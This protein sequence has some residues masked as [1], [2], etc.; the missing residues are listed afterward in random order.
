MSYLNDVILGVIEGIT[1]FLPISSTG[2][3]LLAQHW[4]GARSDTY[5]I[6]IQAGAILAVTLIYRRRL[7]DLATGWR[8]PGSRDYLAK[9]LT[10]FVI[11]AVLGVVVKKAG[12]Q[13]PETVT[14]I[15]WAL[16]IGGVIG[17]AVSVLV[18]HLGM[19]GHRNRFRIAKGPM[20]ELMSFG[21]WIFLS[22]IA[23]FLIFQGDRLVLGA[24]LTLDELGIYNIAYFLGSVPSLLG[25][26]IAG[27]LFIPL[28]RDVPPG[29]SPANA[30]QI[31]RVRLR[32]RPGAPAPEP[33]DSVLRH[34]DLE[35]DPASHTARVD[36]RTVALSAREF[37]LAEEF[38]R[39]PG[40]VLSR[41]QLLDA[42][43]GSDVYVEARTV[44]VHVGRLRKALNLG[45]SPNP[46]RT[47]RSA[48][49]SLDLEG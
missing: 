35:L 5:N 25:Q 10:A 39:S 18:I 15:A 2:H 14:P 42:V 13:L 36:G 34:G 48:G 32:L 16:V 49:Y 45:D 23:G 47:V 43:W 20:A 9:L 3:L 21:R 29:E 31:A 41:E 44:D 28:Y 17:T 19:P 4:L 24:Y 30:R 11:T 33:T 6:V 7:A 12:F 38:L 1:E 26:A 37:A 8:D 46:I 27:R 22:T 40:Q